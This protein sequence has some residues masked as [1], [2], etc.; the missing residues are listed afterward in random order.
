MSSDFVTITKSFRRTPE[1]ILTTTMANKRVVILTGKAGMGHLSIASALDFWTRKFGYNSEVIDIIPPSSDRIYK[2]MMK[3]PQI[4]AAFY[5]SSNNL[6]TAELMI[7][8][9][10]REFTSKLKRFSPLCQQADVVIAT[11]PLIHPAVGKNKVIT[12]VDPSVH[13]SYCCEPCADKYFVF[14][15]ESIAQLKKFK[16]PT[17]KIYSAHPLARESFYRIGKTIINHEDKSKYKKLLNLNPELPL[18]L[19]MAGGG[20]IDRIKPYLD[21][22]AA[23][24]PPGTVNLAFLCGKKKAF[25]RKMRQKYS[26]SNFIFLDWLTEKQMAS[27]MG[28]ADFAI[29]L[30][31]AQMSVEAGLC[32]VPIYIFN[33]IEGQE[34][35]YRQVILN[36]HVGASIYGKPEKQVAILKK[37]L[38]NNQKSFNKSLAIWQKQLLNGPEEYHQLL[39]DIINND[40]HH[41]PLTETPKKNLWQ[42]LIQRIIH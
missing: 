16:I 35:G 33:L 38:P 36:H 27:W 18:G 2:I 22:L 21:Q 34:E 23:S 25:A 7:K 42:N 26:Q 6:M 3:V 24:F 14:W 37:W 4:H 12:I 32:R 28:A 29:A 15:D 40:N 20:W 11:H 5:R 41:T 13:A 9:F 19:I 30:T 8:S 31:L 39:K 1:S 10:Q 17:N